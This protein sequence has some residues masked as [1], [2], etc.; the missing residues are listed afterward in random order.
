MGKSR[1]GVTWLLENRRLRGVK[2]QAGWLID[3]GSVVDFL[4]R[5]KAM[6]ECEE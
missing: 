4:E 2:T 6:R 5:E 3:P 1:Q